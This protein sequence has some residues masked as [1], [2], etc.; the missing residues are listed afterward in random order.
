MIHIKAQ[1]IETALYNA[2]MD[3]FRRGFDSDDRLEINIELT[4]E[5]GFFHR[6]KPY[7]FDITLSGTWVLNRGF[8]ADCYD[9]KITLNDEFGDPAV[10]KMNMTEEQII[11][12]LEDS[13]L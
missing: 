7:N 9:F 12:N 1:Q 10:F 8:Y 3:Q 6:N 2:M 11:I 13:L 5:L 4:E